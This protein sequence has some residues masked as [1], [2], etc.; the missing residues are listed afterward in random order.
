MRFGRRD[1]RFAAALSGALVALGALAGPASAQGADKP[2]G[3]AATAEAVGATAAALI[4][5]AMIAV[6]IGLH[7]SGRM[8]YLHRLARFSE[9]VSGLPA[10]AAL[11]SAVLGSSL[12]TAVIGMYWD[13]S[14]HIDNGRDPGPLANP[15]HYLILIGLY[16]V[17]FA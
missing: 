17:L 7:R 13:I 10:W 2:A 3:G 8:P 14:L 6:L 16:G 12:L 11:P 1:S 15:A 4:C 5:T 9:R